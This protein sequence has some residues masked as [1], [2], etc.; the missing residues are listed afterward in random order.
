MTSSNTPDGPSE[1]DGERVSEASESNGANAER[2]SGATESNG[3]RADETD[4]SRGSELGPYEAVTAYPEGEATA[5]RHA[6]TAAEAGYDGIV[7][8]TRTDAD[9]GAIRDRRGIDVVN[10]VEID[11]S[12]PASA[13]GAVGNY[14]PD[15]TVLAV[16][17]GSAEL[18]RFAVEQSR[19]DVLTTPFA[20]DGDVNH[21]IVE[22]AAA[23]DV[24]VEVNLRPVVRSA[25]G[26]RVRALRKLR[27]LREL[28]AHADAP[29]VVSARPSSHLALRAPRELAAVGEAIGFTAEQIRTGL[30]EWGRLARRNRERRSESF[31][32]PGVRRGR[33]EEDDQ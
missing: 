18:V 29:F 25:G 20:G 2:A 24:R 33:Y 9:L 3:E 14:R 5:D 22:R 27:K 21:V 30:R 28:L 31:I 6:L 7:V 12:D 13:S 19:V 26:E 15:H 16:R 10:A 23:N 1:S 11:A 17:G 32:S 4:R 8:R